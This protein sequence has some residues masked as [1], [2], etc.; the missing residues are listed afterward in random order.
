[1]KVAII[2]P[3]KYLTPF[4][5]FANNSY[6]MALA[7]RVLS[8]EEYKNYYKSKSR[9]GDF[10][11]LDNGA[12][13]LGKSIKLSDLV[14]AAKTIEAKEIVLPDKLRDGVKTIKM[15]RSFFDQFDCHD[16]ELMAVVQGKNK[17][18]WLKCLN[19]YLSMDKVN[20]IGIS[21][22]DAI[23]NEKEFRFSRIKTIDWLVHQKLLPADKKVHLLGLNNSGHI[24]LEKLSKYSFIEGVDTSAPVVHGAFGVRFKKDEHYKKIRQYL[25]PEILLNNKQIKDIKEN[26][27]LLFDC[28]AYE[29]GS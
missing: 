26:I 2:P 22:T 5:S 16:F 19:V 24:E 14:T 10:V 25:E 1:M 27:K 3:T 7:Q 13:E 18:E 28:A 9:A 23:F 20:V 8:D 12:C 21:S 4:A 17:E 11:I 29:P 6:H 15:V